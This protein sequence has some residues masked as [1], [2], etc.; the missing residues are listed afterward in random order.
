[1]IL[2]HTLPGASQTN[3]PGEVFS[4]SKDAFQLYKP[5][6]PGPFAAQQD[7]YNHTAVQVSA[8]PSIA[9]TNRIHLVLFGMLNRTLGRSLQP[10]IGS[11]FQYQSEQHTPNDALCLRD[12]EWQ[13]APCCVLRAWSAR[14]QQ[15]LLVRA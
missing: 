10:L 13:R 14:T 9:G 6:L 11:L 1:M 4:P 2:A 12:G 5:N 3:I 7:K 15:R 8:A